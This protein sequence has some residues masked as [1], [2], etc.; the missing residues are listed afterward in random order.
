MEEEVREWEAG[1]ANVCYQPML[2]D[3][4]PYIKQIKREIRE[5]QDRSCPL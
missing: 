3:G 1:V 2:I 5:G 4:A